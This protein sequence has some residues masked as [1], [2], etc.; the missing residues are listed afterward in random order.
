VHIAEDI[1]QCVAFL[2]YKTDRGIRLGGTAFFYSVFITS[3]FRGGNLVTAR[4]VVDDIRKRAT[5][6]GLFT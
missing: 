6:D 5:V 3:E 1:N 2:G 4:H